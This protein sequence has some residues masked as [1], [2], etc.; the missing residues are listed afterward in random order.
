MPKKLLILA[1]SDLK[2]GSNGLLPAL[3]RYDG[4]TFRVLRKFLRGYQWPKSV[5]IGVLSARYG[6]F[7]ILRGI[8]SY[9]MRMDLATA[10]AKA[11]ECCTVLSKWLGFHSSVHLSLGKDYMAAVQPALEQLGY[12]PDVFH[13]GIGQKLSQVK[14]FLERTSPP[15]RVKAHVEGGTGRYAYFLPDWDDQIDPNF[16]FESDSFSGRTRAERKD[17][18]CSVL[19][20]PKRMS[21]GILISLAQHGAKKGPLKRLEGTEIGALSPLPLRR[22]YGLTVDQYLFGDCGAYSYVNEEVPAISVDQ[23]VAL[24][25]TYG[26]D[27]GASVDHIPVRKITS[28]GKFKVLSDSERQ[29]RINVTRQNAELFIESARERKVQFNPVGTIQSL[30]S[31]GYAQS[32]R[33]YYDLGYRHMAIGGLVPLQDS[34]IENIV[35]AVMDVA[36][37]LTDRPWI[38]LFG[39]FRPKLQQLF[40]HLHVDSFD[41]ASYFR[42][43]WLRSDQNYLSADGHWYAALRVPMTSDSRTLSRLK[44]INADVDKL[45]REERKVLMLLCQYDRDEAGI[46]E[47]LDAVLSYDGHLARSSETKSMR[48]KYRRTLEERPWR[49]C[50]CNF[51]KSL[52][53]HMLIFR[54]ANRN[55]RRG[56]HNTLILYG[57]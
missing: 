46:N 33:H 38:H 20:R 50:K 18:H 48:V 57:T 13:G 29:A 26:F 41:S 14:S 21:D 3:D 7:G 17:K 28:R 42:K 25:E 56:A 36:D 6:L 24:Y 9:D 43:A 10:R 32:V 51:C 15:R 37:Q 44:K 34:K 52:G 23:A 35:R 11:P 2:R 4:P 54:G 8:E 39:I 1:C 47:V 55:R 53:I 40:R 31:Q 12:K 22:H 16:D 27:F 49:N 45:E 19:M 5:S 30:N